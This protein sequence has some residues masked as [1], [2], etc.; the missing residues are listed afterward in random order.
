MTLPRHLLPAL[1]ALWLSSGAGPAHAG[2]AR[3]AWGGKTPKLAPKSEAS[4]PASE[5][6]PGS[7]PLATPSTAAPGAPGGPASMQAPGAAAAGASTG[8]PGAPGATAVPPIPKPPPPLVKQLGRFDLDLPLSLLAQLPELRGCAVPFSAPSGHG[9]CLLPANEERLARVD[10]AWDDGKPGGELLALRLVFDPA[11][12]PPLTELEWQLTR[13]WGAPAL[14]QLRREHDQKIFTLQ[15]EDPEHRA[16]LEAAAPLLQPSRAVAVVLERK[17]RPL[18]GE[19]STL[20][21][22]P[23]PGMR[24]RMARRMEWEGVTHAAVWGTSLTP[25]QEALGEAGPAFANQRSYV[26]LW[27]LEPLAAGKRRWRALW[28]RTAGSDD[29]DND[30]QR[31]LR[32]DTRDLTGDGDPDLLV[33]L[34]CPSCAGS[35]S[36]V[37]VKTVRTGKLVDLL[38]KRELFRAEVSVGGVGQLRI[39]EPEGEDGVTVLT[40]AYDKSKGAFVL[41]HEERQGHARPV[42]ER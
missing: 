32:V 10:L 23:F 39:R 7:V 9:E 30:P 1:A 41:A 26:G 38:S 28:E 37:L 24:I 35:T 5:Q 34:S 29:E 19:L 27:R 42:E 15:W 13:A 20:R 33:E 14:E 11:A 31:I 12:A 8:P 17:P 18:P 36:E 21:P 16:T 6:Q 3:I 2:R 40:Y 22:R 4:K 25:A